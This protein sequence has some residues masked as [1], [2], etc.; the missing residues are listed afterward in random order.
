MRNNE[1]NKKEMFLIIGRNR[2]KL[3]NI[4]TYGISSRVFYYQKVNK[5]EE[6]CWFIF[7]YTYHRWH[8]DTIM[9][10]NNKQERIRKMNTG[11]PMEVKNTGS[12]G[13]L[14]FDNNGEIEEKSGIEPNEG[15]IFGKKHKY[16][17]ITTYQNENYR[18][19]DFDVDFDVEEKCKEI[20]DKFC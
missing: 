3:S 8:G 12:L 16:L 19:Y 5:V 15:D 11:E 14:V 17:Y 2:I 1:I 9:L 18:F 6:E 7:R 10:D 4:K 20:D 13:M